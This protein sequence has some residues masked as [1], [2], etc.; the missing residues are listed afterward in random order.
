[1]TE[2]HSAGSGPEHRDVLLEAG[3]PRQR[4]GDAPRMAKAALAN[5]RF[6]QSDATGSY[7]TGGCAGN[8]N[9]RAR[10][11]RSNTRAVLLI[12]LSWKHV[13]TRFRPRR[14]LAEEAVATAREHGDRHAG[15][16]VEHRHNV[17]LSHET[18]DQRRQ[19]NRSCTGSPKRWASNLRITRVLRFF[20]RLELVTS[21]CTR[22]GAGAGGDLAHARATECEWIVS[23]M[24]FALAR[25]D[26]D[27]DACSDASNASLTIGT[28]RIPTPVL[29]TPCN[30]PRFSS[31][32]G[33]AAPRR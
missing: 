13:C 31:I 3:T 23:W 7:R 30:A 28:D 12:K 24:T 19:E 6:W 16:R 17:L 25:W 18:V 11:R 8:R 32:A 5:G 21:R 26:G 20:W 29:R 22:H 2:R 14:A 4:I 33:E 1:M 27:L 9:R 10:P 15:Q